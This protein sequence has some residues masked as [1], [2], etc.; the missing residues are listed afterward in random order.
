MA[1][2]WKHDCSGF[3]IGTVDCRKHFTHEFH[4]FISQCFALWLSNHANLLLQLD[5]QPAIHCTPWQHSQLS[6]CSKSVGQS[7]TSGLSCDQ[8]V[9][10]SLRPI[11]G[12][13]HYLLHISFSS[14]AHMPLQHL[15]S[16]AV[17]T[18]TVSY[19]THASMLLY[20]QPQTWF[21][22][23]WYVRSRSFS[24]LTGLWTSWVG[25]NLWFSEVISLMNNGI[26]AARPHDLW[27]TFLMRNYYVTNNLH[28]DRQC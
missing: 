24:S 26:V 14:L 9:Y 19:Q 18:C 17:I 12:L 10:G 25:D 15:L 6:N 5:N 27:E 3:N 28:L 7:L 16:L 1:V 23:L 13:G 11:V 22:W 20:V 21:C 4:Y 8:R 2:D